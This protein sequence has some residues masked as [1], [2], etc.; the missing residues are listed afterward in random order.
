[1]YT[2]R[3]N[4]E[5]G[6]SD[7]AM[8]IFASFVLEAF[9]FA[10]NM[11][12]LMVLMAKVTPPKVEAT[13]FAFLTSTRN[14]HGVLG[15]LVSAGIIQALGINRENLGNIWE[16]V[17]IQFFVAFVPIAL[18]LCLIPTKAQVRHVQTHLEDHYT[19]AKE[20]KKAV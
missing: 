17:L 16:F 11:L 19:V 8:V 4:L 5:L 13:I 18:V 12:P 3:Y 7:T 14:M 20:D 1:M 10:F 9:I 6:I 2:T 15:S